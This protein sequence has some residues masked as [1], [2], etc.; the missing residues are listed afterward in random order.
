[1]RNNHKLKTEGEVMKHWKKIIGFIAIAALAVSELWSRDWWMGG[2]FLSA[3]FFTA[4]DKD[5]ATAPMKIVRNI[6]FALMIILGVISIIVKVL[7]H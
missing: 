5:G 3:A 2:M 6:L 1:M 7:H 4:I